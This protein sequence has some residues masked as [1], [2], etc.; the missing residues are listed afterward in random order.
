[1]DRLVGYFCRSRRKD[2]GV[3]VAVQRHHSSAWASRN[4]ALLAPWRTLPLAIAAALLVVG[5]ATVLLVARPTAGSVADPLL[6][7][8]GISNPAAAAASGTLYVLSDVQRG[9]GLDGAVAGR[10]TAIDLAAGR[11]RYSLTTGIDVDATLSPDGLRVYVADIDN[12]AGD[13]SAVDRLRGMDARTGALLWQTPLQDRV[14]YITGQPSTLAVSQDGS[15]LYVYSYPWRHLDASPSAS[16]FPY[17]LQAFDAATGQAVLGQIALPGCDA[18]SLHVPPRGSELLV[19]CSATNDIR[20]VNLSA[21]RV[22]G[23]LSI[24]RVP[25]TLGRTGGI[26]ASMLSPDG[27]RL[28]LVNADLRVVVVDMDSRSVL[29]K[30]DLGRRNYVAVPDG[31]AALSPDGTRLFVAVLPAPDA[32]GAD[33]IQAFDTQT[34]QQV[35]SVTTGRPL[36]GGS[37][38]VSAN[39]RHLYGIGHTFDGQAMPQA[40]TVL[41][42]GE[43]GAQV[44]APITRRGELIYRV[45]TGP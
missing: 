35:E 33:V 9:G 36:S 21:G 26:A 39:G 38:T 20:F 1:M 2:A 4:Q 43:A 40:D 10:L 45:F 6:D 22:D 3:S 29:E 18:G 30:R 11:Q 14:K 25:L 31:H 34:W 16:E 24:P 37:L 7:D 32:R 23:R 44:G 13:A 5:A 41:A 15:R 19:V 12:S 27:H 8:V 42:W 28:Y 17:W